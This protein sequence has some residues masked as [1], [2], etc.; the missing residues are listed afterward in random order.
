VA[1]IVERASSTFNGTYMKR[2]FSLSNFAIAAIILSPCCTS[3]KANVSQQSI[4]DINLKRGDIIS[5]SPAGYQFGTLEFGTS[6]SAAVKDD[7]NTAIKLLHSFEYD[8]AEKQFAKVIDKDPGC[9]MA[10]WGVA[11]SNFHPLWSPATEPELIKGSKA[12]AAAKSIE[13]KTKREEAYIDAI[14]AYY[15]N[16]SK[17]D[18]RQRAQNFEA[19]MEKLYTAYPDDMEAAIFYSLALDAAADPTDKTYAKQKKAGAILNALYTKHP[20]HPGIVHYI[21]HTFDSPELASLGLTAARKY[22]SVAP[23]S[24]HALHMPSHI[25]TRLGL[26][27]EC[28]QSNIASVSAAKCY[29]ESSGI[30][31]HWDEEMHGLDYLV[32]GYLQKGDNE[33]AKQQLDYVNAIKDVEPPSFKVAYAFAAIPARYVVENKMWKEAATLQINQANVDWIKFPWEHAIVHFARLLGSVNT[34]NKRAVENEFNELLIA[35]ERLLKKNDALKANKVQIQ[36]EASKAWMLFNEGKM[37]EA[38]AAMNVAADLEDKTGKPPVT[39]GD[40][41]PARELL[42][43]M[44]LQMNKPAMALAAYEASLQKTPNRFNGLYGAATAAQQS[45][46]TTKTKLY[47]QQLVSVAG[48]S[49]RSEIAEAKKFLSKGL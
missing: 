46:N 19:A 41:I 40:I 23:S 43:D 29:A 25:F 26:W 39:P 21:I 48:N 17:L 13:N 44:L 45:G 38:I 1:E 36:I 33:H 10:Y 8:E 27:D 42:G 24:A 18:H 34:G 11:M 16:F 6:C 32:Y 14:A 2:S 12:I 28:I 5:C 31:G 15:T 35:H 4:A 30:K 47:Y 7:F 9:A 49:A 20:N 22:A 37:D 3:K